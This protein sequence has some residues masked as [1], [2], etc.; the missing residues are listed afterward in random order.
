MYI[1]ITCVYFVNN[2]KLH[3][4]NSDSFYSINN[5]K[6]GLDHSKTIR[7]RS[8]TFRSPFKHIFDGSLP[9]TVIKI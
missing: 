6:C 5:C 2:G 8:L 9:E 7:E 1:L 3:L 4:F